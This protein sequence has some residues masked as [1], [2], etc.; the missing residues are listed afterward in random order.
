MDF[1]NSSKEEILTFLDKVSNND[2]M[3]CDSFPSLEELNEDDE[4]VCVTSLSMNYLPLFMTM[5]MFCDRRQLLP[6][7]WY[8]RQKYRHCHYTVEWTKLASSIF[9]GSLPADLHGALL[10]SH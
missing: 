6:Y 4:P 9:I 10:F 2:L 5:I 8:H 1:A 7:S 3:A